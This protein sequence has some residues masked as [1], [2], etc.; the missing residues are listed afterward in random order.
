MEMRSIFTGDSCPWLLGS[1]LLVKCNKL[2]FFNCKTLV[3]RPQYNDCLQL[4]VK[5]WFFAN[6]GQWSGSCWYL[7]L[8]ALSFKFSPHMAANYKKVSP[9]N[10]E[11]FNVV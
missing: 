5:R 6:R 3:F 7:S 9:G 4:L 2:F 10:A 11:H 1:S 8:F